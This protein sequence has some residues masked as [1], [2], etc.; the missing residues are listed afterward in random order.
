M[1]CR[2]KTP[3]GACHGTGVRGGYEPIQT[4][5]GPMRTYVLRACACG[6]PPMLPVQ[7]DVV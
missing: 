4:P 5:W 1:P 6:N 3:C 7:H 2:C